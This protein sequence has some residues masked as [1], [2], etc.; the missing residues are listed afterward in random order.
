MC[1][2]INVCELQFLLIII[3]LSN[4]FLLHA[5]MSPY[6]ATGKYKAKDIDSGQWN[7]VHTLDKVI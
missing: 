6:F 3:M 4:G 1:K 2:N 7:T 5:L